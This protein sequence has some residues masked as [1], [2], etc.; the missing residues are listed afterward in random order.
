MKILLIS[1]LPPPPGGISTWS[2]NILAFF[3][4]KKNEIEIINQNNALTYRQ[5]TN[6]NYTNRIYTGVIHSLKIIRLFIK[7]IKSEKPQLIHLTSSA[8]LALFKDLIIVSI[9]KYY[10]IPI[11]YHLHFGRI[12]ALSKTKNWEWFLLRFLIHRSNKTIVIDIPSF[13]TLKTNGIQNVVNIP[14]PISFELE[15][16][17]ISINKQQQRINNLIFVGHIIKDKGVFELVE[18]CVSI[19]QIDYLQLIGPYEESIKRDLE[20][21][22]SKRENGK[23]LSFRGTLDKENVTNEMKKSLTIVLPSYTEGFPNVI[24]EGMALGCAIIAS[25]VGAI[26]DMI[27]NDRVNSC[28]ICVEPKNT[29]Q[30][31][32]AILES[33]KFPLK[34]VSMGQNGNNRVL[35]N[36]TLEIVANQLLKEWRD[37]II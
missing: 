34:A 2:E 18:A 14:N 21:I 5:I 11:V 3:K 26:P 7:N 33:I 1:P 10:R 36:Y 31:K 30:L 6:V 12:P 22:A 35:K 27:L 24:L 16:E 32:G 9:S 20:V 15:K 25:N 13:N 28:G 37:I 29:A 8:S 17:S 4:T 23:W 19:P